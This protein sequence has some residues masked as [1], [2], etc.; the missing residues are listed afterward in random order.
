M[1]AFES[2]DNKFIFSKFQKP[3]ISTSAATNT[4]ASET[5]AKRAMVA[6]PLNSK[7]SSQTV[8]EEFESSLKAEERRKMDSFFINSGNMVPLNN[9]LSTVTAKNLKLGTDVVVPKDTL[10]NNINVSSEF[11][12]GKYFLKKTVKK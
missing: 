6:T 1:L 7:T 11:F 10:L 5:Q 8:P 9:N 12:G 2:G 4:D 3:T